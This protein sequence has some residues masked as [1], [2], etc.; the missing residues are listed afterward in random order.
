[1]VRLGDGA[2]CQF[3]EIAILHIE[4]A[5]LVHFRQMTRRSV[6]C[7]M[8]ATCSWMPLVHSLSPSAISMTS[9][10]AFM[11]ESGVL[12]SWLASVTNRR[13]LA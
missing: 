10:L 11:T 7:A 5:A 12:G 9:V 6:S 4:L 8:R 2:L 13:C 3:G 1:M